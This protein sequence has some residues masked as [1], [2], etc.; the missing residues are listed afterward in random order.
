MTNPL[1]YIDSIMFELVDGYWV[2]SELCQYLAPALFT[3][4]Y[5]VYYTNI[6][7]Y[8]L[9][10]YDLFKIKIKNELI[11]TIEYQFSQTEY[12]KSSDR[13]YTFIEQQIGTV[14]D[15]LNTKITIPDHDL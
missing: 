5:N 15:V 1:N 6:G 4:V 10:K 11:S 3:G 9:V 2:V 8:N 12:Y 14:S 13:S 7:D